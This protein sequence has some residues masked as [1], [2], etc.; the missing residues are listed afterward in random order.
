MPSLTTPP[1]RRSAA[2]GAV[3][4]AA[5]TAPTLAV[6]AAPPG[7]GAS[8]APA[9]VRAEPPVQ[10]LDPAGAGLRA[11]DVPLPA[12][13]RTVETATPFA[14]VGVT[15]T[16]DG[17]DRAVRVRT[18]S[19]DGWSSWRGLEQIGDGPDRRT[20]ERSAGVAATD[21]QWVGTADAVRVD[22][23]GAR[24]AD[25][26]LVL[27]APDGTQVRSPARPQPRL[28][29][30]DTRN[31]WSPKPAMRGRAQWGA[32]PAL[33]SGA[34]RYNSTI[35]QVH[36]HHTV[37][38]NTYARDDV[39]GLLRGIYRYHTQNL[40][41]SDIGYNFL[42]DRFGRTWV[43]RAGGPRKPVLGAHTL[44]FN[45]TSTGVAVI[46]NFED[47]RPRRNVVSAL[48]RLSAWKLDRYDRKPRGRVSVTSSGSDRFPAGERPR[49]PTIDGHRDTNQTAC[50]GERLYAELP[51]IRR[52]AAARIAR[53]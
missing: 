13:R 50:P 46:G 33:R 23:A 32:D 11:A 36:V 16:D 18:R 43:G 53:W 42:V 49:L 14:M 8:A 12:D 26:T 3:V 17:A 5:L 22:V 51:T 10:R 44:G 34:A 52:R 6:T 45:S 48:V 1:G 21:L 29:A 7:S 47:A 2:L 24:P 35:Q 37:N 4:A 15:W 28:L 31:P 19:E 38:S 27:I 30:R 41:W 9:P 25:L 20:R 40:G 39:P